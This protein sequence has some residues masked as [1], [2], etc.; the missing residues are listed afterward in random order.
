[1]KIF[2]TTDTHFGHYSLADEYRARPGDFEKR[3]VRNWRRMIGD[4]DLVIHLGDVVVGRSVDWTSIVPSLSGRKILVLGNHDR[5][6]ISWY[7][8]NGFDFCCS[9][10][11]WEVFGLRI[12]L[13][14]EPA[15]EGTFDLNI[16]GHLH[17]GRH[18]EYGCD[19]R[20]HLL[21]LEDTSYQPRLLKSLVNEW[22]K[23]N[24]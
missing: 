1:M 4:D 20:H 7:L 21:S 11:V 19:A 2:V 13:S 24:S 6:S 23:S 14:H 5:K 12:L 9:S 10:F 8:G 16:H 3:I 18:R 22:R 17:G 15:F